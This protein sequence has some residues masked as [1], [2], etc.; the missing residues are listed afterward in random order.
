MLFLG[1]EVRGAALSS[2]VRG[3]I[4]QIGDSDLPA[5]AEHPFPTGQTAECPLRAS[6]RKVPFRPKADYRSW[7][8]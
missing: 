3:Q 7:G 6:G 2:S 8:F 1:D 5:K 4:G